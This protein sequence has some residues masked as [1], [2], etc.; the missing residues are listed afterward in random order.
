MRV[1]QQN[2]RTTQL[3]EQKM[4]ILSLFLSKIS[5]NVSKKWKKHKIVRLTQLLLESIEIS[6]K[7]QCKKIKKYF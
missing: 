2:V 4:P 5:K 3:F 1:A 6:M 7:I